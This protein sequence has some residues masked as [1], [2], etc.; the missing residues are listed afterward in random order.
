[1]KML[2]MLSLVVLLG[3][4]AQENRAS[5]QQYAQVPTYAVGYQNGCGSYQ[6]C[7]GFYQ[8]GSQY[9]YNSYCP[10]G[11]VAAYHPYYGVGC[12]QVPQSYY[13]SYS[14]YT[15]NPNYYY[16]YGYN[17]YYTLTYCQ[18]GYTTCGGGYTC[19]PCGTG[20]GYG[21]CTRY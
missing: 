4:C 21:F 10:A 3:A 12:V 15:Y 7:G 11:T 14:P 9:A 2:M 6:S 18:V 8:G 13:F 20:Y 17:S 16:Y 1:M 5:N 19:T